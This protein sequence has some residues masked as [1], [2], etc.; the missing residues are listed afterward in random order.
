MTACKTGYRENNTRTLPQRV[1]ND[2]GRPQALSRSVLEPIYQT[3]RNINNCTKLSTICLLTAICMLEKDIFSTGSHYRFSCKVRVTCA[4]WIFFRCQGD[5]DKPLS[6]EATREES[7]TL[8][9]GD[10]P[11]Q[12]DHEDVPDADDQQGRSS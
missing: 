3:K 9:R 11:L 1:A 2:H 8:Y 12:D 5:D 6:I 10:S 7:E 4:A